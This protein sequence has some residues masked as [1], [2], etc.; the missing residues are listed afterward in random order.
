MVTLKMKSDPAVCQSAGE[1]L[2]NG[3][4]VAFPTDTVYGLGAVYTDEK[5]V[6]K[7]F[8]AKGRDEGKPLS[9]L[10]SD[11]EQVRE[12]ASFI[13]EGAEALMRR[14]WPGALT[15]IFRKSKKVPGCVVAG[16]DTVGIRMPADETALSIIRAAGAPLA[17]PSANTSGKRSSVTAEDVEE[18][19]NGRIDM[20]IDG[21]ACNIGVSSTVLDMTGEELKILREG[22][23]TAEMIE[24]TLEE[25]GKMEKK[26]IAIGSD[27]AGYA[28]KLEL[29]K[30]LEER[31]YETTD[32]GT[33]SDA[34]CDYPVYAH[35][36]AHAVVRG[37]ADKGL[38]VC[39]TGI[40]MSMA[41][42]KVRGIRAAVLGDEFSAQA[43]R[44]HND[45]NILCL[46]ARVLDVEKAIKL[47]DIFL[48]T[49]FSE[50]ENHIRR[51]GRLEDTP[52]E[53]IKEETI[54]G[55]GRY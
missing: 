18:D 6:E 38:L 10:I 40:G 50:G 25:A 39:G 27:H 42:N 48:D 47:L 23:V 13:P 34:S 22:T 11:I 45:A 51:I 52:D 15:L 8:A 41:A 28:M 9:I 53:E 31:G 24:K 44:E 20:I 43:T 36:V 37:E 16:G 33:F 30:H 3:G 7:I 12:L 49:P 29:K 14:F 17:A 35:A 54:Q 4:I 32:Y 5:A 26:M 21:G 19:L 2:K 1:I 46:G 55:F